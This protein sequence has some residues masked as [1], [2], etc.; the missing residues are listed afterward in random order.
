MCYDL[1]AFAYLYAAHATTF[2]AQVLNRIFEHTLLQDQPLARHSTTPGLSKKRSVGFNLPP[3]Y[4]PLSTSS[5]VEI[6]QPHGH[7]HTSDPE[8]TLRRPPRASKSEH[9]ILTH[10][11]SEPVPF[12]RQD[13]ASEPGSQGS[14]SRPFS[15]QTYAGP[16]SSLRGRKSVAQVIRESRAVRE[17]E[18]ATQKVRCSTDADTHTQQHS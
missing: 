16:P 2:T 4:S 7:V 15:S 9:S 10:R 12:T 18:D 1:A 13:R 17:S 6:S 14:H 11:A 3:S 5:S 8:R